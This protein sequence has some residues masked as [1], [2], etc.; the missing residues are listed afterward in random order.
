MNDLR[1]SFHMYAKAYTRRA[2]QS[3]VLMPEAKYINA[4]LPTYYVKRCY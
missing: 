4:A 3:Q 2:I 1:I